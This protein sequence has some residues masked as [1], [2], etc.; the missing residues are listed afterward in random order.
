MYIIKLQ[1]GHLSYNLISQHLQF[2][3]CKTELHLIECPHMQTR[4]SVSRLP[5]G[6]KHPHDAHFAT[7]LAHIENHLH[8]FSISKEQARHT[9]QAT[10]LNKCSWFGLLPQTDSAILCT[11]ISGVAGLEFLAASCVPNKKNPRNFRRECD[12]M[13]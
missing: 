3:A 2:E 12:G 7:P 8:T 5:T 10:S 11:S 6:L 4:A 13:M 9:L 1:R